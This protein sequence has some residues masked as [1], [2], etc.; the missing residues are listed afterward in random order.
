LTPPP[1]LFLFPF[2]LIVEYLVKEKL[3]QNSING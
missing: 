3:L 1:I 2:W